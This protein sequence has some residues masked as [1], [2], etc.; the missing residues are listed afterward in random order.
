MCI[1]VSAGIVAAGSLLESCA[2]LPVFK[3]T[4]DNHK[5]RVPIAQFAL[6]KVITIRP[7]GFGY[8][9]GLRKEDNGS[10]TALLLRCTHADNEL[11]N[12]GRGFVCSL[13]GSQ[14]DKEGAV[15]KGPAERPL[16][17]YKTEETKTEVIIS[18]D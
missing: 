18:I 13:H 1:A 9:I 15:K 16:H 14:F 5:I 7:K 2:P 10:Y 12:T 8:D 3:T 6:N 17:K 4:I 11:I